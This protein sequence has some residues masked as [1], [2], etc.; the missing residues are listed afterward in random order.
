[1][2]KMP[3]EIEFVADKILNNKS[4]YDEIKKLLIENIRKLNNDSMGHSSFCNSLRKPN[5]LDKKLLK[6]FGINDR[7]MMQSFAQIGFHQESRMYSSLYYQK[8]PISS[9]KHSEEFPNSSE[10]FIIF[11]KSVLSLLFFHVFP[12]TSLSRGN[13]ETI[14][15]TATKLHTPVGLGL[16]SCCNVFMSRSRLPFWI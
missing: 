16:P 7:Q 5:G 9:L 8:I 12:Q 4:L 10:S 11:V 14:I 3:K 1:M 6:I 15:H 13:S 2:H